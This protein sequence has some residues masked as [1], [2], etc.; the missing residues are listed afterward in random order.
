MIPASGQRQ[1]APSLLRTRIFQWMRGP[2]FARDIALVLVIKLVLL[3]ALKYAFFS[4]PQAEDMNM[5]PAAVA[6][7]ILAVP[8]ASRPQPSV[9]QPP[10]M[11]PQRGD[12]HARD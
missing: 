6:Q 10:A 12:R 8:T 7:A 9:S 11:P 1:R 3:M 5:P 2:T 4:H